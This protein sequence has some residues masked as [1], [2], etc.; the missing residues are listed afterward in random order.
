MGKDEETVLIFRGPTAEGAGALEEALGKDYEAFRKPKLKGIATKVKDFAKWFE[1]F[2]VDSIELW[3][4]AVVKTGSLTG[5]II[6]GEGKGGVK[7]V[8]KP[9]GAGTV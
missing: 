8:I 4:E 7:V 1:G 2:K 6:A 3:L 9:K 5:L